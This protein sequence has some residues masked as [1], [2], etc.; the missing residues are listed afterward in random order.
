[1]ISFFEGRFIQFGLFWWPG[2][3][4]S[5][6]SATLRLLGVGSRQLVLFYKAL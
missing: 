4:V 2:L 6:Q 1:L 3:P 5:D